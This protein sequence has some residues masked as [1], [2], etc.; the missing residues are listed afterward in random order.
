MSRKEHCSGL[1]IGQAMP[2]LSWD[3]LRMERCEIENYREE[4]AGSDMRKLLTAET[5]GKA[6]I[7]LDCSSVFFRG[8]RISAGCQEFVKCGH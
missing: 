7:K 6:D 2:S 8:D 5:A 1:C 3:C 4:V